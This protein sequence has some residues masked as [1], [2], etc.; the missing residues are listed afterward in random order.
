M[1]TA[2]EDSHNNNQDKDAAAFTSHLKVPSTSILQLLQPHQE[3][4][5]KKGQNQEVLQQVQQKELLDKDIAALESFLANYTPAMSMTLRSAEHLTE[6]AGQ[7]AAHD[8]AL[9]VLVNKQKECPSLFWFYPKK[10]EL[11]NWLS[12]PLKCLLQDSLMMVV[13]CPVTLCVVKCGPD[14]VGWEIRSPKAWVK[15]WGPAILA[16]IYVMQAAV[17]AGR[18]VGIP[19]PTLPSVGDISNILGLNVSCNILDNSMSAVADQVSAENLMNS[20]QGFAS[21]TEQCLEEHKKEMEG[22][23]HKMQLQQDQQRRQNQSSKSSAP[24]PHEEITLGA[25]MPTTMIGASYHSIHTFLTT[26]E[27]AM[28]GKLEDQ[29]RGSM[30]RVMAEDGEVEWVSVQAVDAWKQMHSAV[31]VPPIPSPYTAPSSNRVVS[32]PPTVSTVVTSSWLAVRLRAKGTKDES[33]VLCERILIDEEEYSEEHLLGSTPH[34]HFTFEYLH[35]IGITA[36]G[37]QQ[38]LI[39]IHRELMVEYQSGAPV[40]PF[41]PESAASFT[42]DEKDAMQKE[43]AALKC[44]LSEMKCKSGKIESSVP[45]QVGS[46]SSGGG[47]GLKLKQRNEASTINPLTGQEYSMDELILKVAALEANVSSAQR[48]IGQLGSVVQTHDVDLEDLKGTSSHTNSIPVSSLS[49]Q[50]HVDQ[51]NDLLRKY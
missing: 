11:R 28:L 22:L 45:S 1:K 43:L 51:K 38:K 3:L 49:S 29:L 46:N 35:S 40:S 50:E 41:S 32:I 37:L 36:R 21:V 44:D 47:G 2:T 39:T 19:L 20:L 34:T 16:S 25:D 27:N 15:K 26:G 5:L 9:H 10:R 18:I 30:E 48:D 33:I 13:V 4:Q 6:I 8:R 42:S 31:K 17:L 14:G 24:P 12:N 7:L 23:I